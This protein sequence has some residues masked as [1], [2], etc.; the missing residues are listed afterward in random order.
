MSR[1]G[2]FFPEEAWDKHTRQ[3]K[4]AYQSFYK[5]CPPVSDFLTSRGIV[6]DDQIVRAIGI[7]VFISESAL[8]GR[9]IDFRA[10][11]PGLQGSYYNQDTS[12]FPEHD[13]PPDQRP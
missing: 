8:L 6:G 2:N 4:A 7:S 9:R 11:S 5:A 12:L 3:G 10:V 1:G 13:L